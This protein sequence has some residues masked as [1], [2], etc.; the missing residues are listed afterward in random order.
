MRMN[1]NG[2]GPF[3]AFGPAEGVRYMLEEVLAAL[4]SPGP[5]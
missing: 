5:A 4:S 3:M 2:V 1:T